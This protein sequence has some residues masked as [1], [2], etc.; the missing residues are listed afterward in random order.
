WQLDPMFDPA[1]VVSAVEDLL[2]LIDTLSDGVEPEDLSA[3][4]EALQSIAGL[5]TAIEAI[6]RS[7]A[8][9][10]VTVP[11]G[12]ELAMFAEDVVQGLFVAYVT[13]TPGLGPTARLVGLVESVTVDEASVGGILRPRAAR[14]ERLRPEAIVDLVSDP[15]GHL[16]ARLVPNDWATPEDVLVTHLL[17]VQHLGPALRSIGGDWRTHPDALASPQ[18]VATSGRLGRVEIRVPVPDEAGR[19]RFGIEYELLSAAN[20]DAAGR[21]GPGVELAPYGG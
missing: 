9:G 18:D 6:F 5:V 19:I 3:F 21:S 10:G 12:D 7:I 11:T 8:E 4:L 16:R 14:L 15:V 17:L 1:P 13:R 20:Q 2:E